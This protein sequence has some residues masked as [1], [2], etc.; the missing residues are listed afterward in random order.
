MLSLLRIASEKYKLK[1]P[2][3]TD[4]GGNFASESPWLAL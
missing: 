3:G 1:M 2:H 4:R